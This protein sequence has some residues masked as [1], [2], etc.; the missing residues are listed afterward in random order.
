[1][2]T[3]SY[4]LLCNGKLNAEGPFAKHYSDLFDKSAKRFPN[5]IWELQAVHEDGRVV[6]LDYHPAEDVDTE[7]AAQRLADQP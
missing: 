6:V 4:R 7:L 5:D 1:M 2:T 3:Q